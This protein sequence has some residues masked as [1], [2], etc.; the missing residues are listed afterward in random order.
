MINKYYKLRIKIMNFKIKTIYRLETVC[1][2][3][4]QI[5]MSKK[6]EFTFTLSCLEET[7]FIKEMDKDDI[8]NLLRNEM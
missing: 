2:K 7:D 1:F 5:L 3:M 8:L 6:Y 4:R